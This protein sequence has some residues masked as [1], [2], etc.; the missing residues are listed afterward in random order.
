MENVDVKRYSM[1]MENIV[2]NAIQIVKKIIDFLSHKNDFIL[3]IL[4]F[5]MFWNRLE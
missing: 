2:T 5:N 4:R 1:I 3:L